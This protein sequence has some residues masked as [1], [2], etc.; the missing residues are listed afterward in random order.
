MSDPN[1]G[2]ANI[3]DDSAT[4]GVQAEA[5]HGDVYVYQVLSDAPPERKF[6]VGVLYLTGGMPARAREC[7]REAV[8]NGQVTSHYCYYLLLAVLSGR[9]LQQVPKED[10]SLLRF[11]QGKLVDKMDDEWTQAIKVIN[12]LLASLQAPDVDPL[13]IEEQLEELIDARRDEILRSLEM[14][15]KGPVQDGFWTR[16]FE[17]ARRDRC[18]H[19]RLQRVWKFFQ[20]EPAKARVRPPRPPDTTIREWIL[21]ITSGTILLASIYHISLQS[22]QHSWSST[23]VALLLVGT[24]CYAFTKNGVEWCFRATRV[25]AKDLMYLTAER[26]LSSTRQGFADKIDRQFDEYFARYVP[27]DVRRAEW[28]THIA[29]IRRVLRDEVVEIYRESRTDAKQVAWLTRYLVANVK[30]RW[31]KGVL[32]E[33]REQLRVSAF[34]KVSFAIGAMVL[35]TGGTVLTWNGL[36]VAPFSV[37]AAGIIMGAVGRSTV[38]GWLRIILEHKRFAADQA[39]STQLLAERNAAFYRWKRK[40]SDRPGD[41]EMAHWLDC[42]RK[43]LMEEA[44]RHYKLQP[45]DLIAH[46]FIEAPAASYKRA[47]VRK[48][49]WRYSRYTILVFLL[50]EDGVRQMT[51]D[52]DFE[53]ATLHNRVRINYRYESVAAVQATEADDAHRTFEL[54][55]MNGAPIKVEVT[56]PAPTVDL[57]TGEDMRTVSQVTLD[58]AGLAS[59]LHILEGVAAEGKEWISQERKREQDG[60]ADLMDTTDGLLG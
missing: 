52:L 17:S 7:I 23:A 5:V 20:P 34:T 18:D 24:G 6:E 21:S 15:L 12:A 35:T 11:A 46:A 43:A 60:L 45:H 14:L 58:S 53:K 40:L 19:Q 37:T 4:V 56:G 47:R 22:W 48:G 2:R 33:Y 31:Q 42:D 25:K 39:E 3:A 55:L 13:A 54:T 16:S 9:T 32:W 57:E 51:V 36:H 29:G 50:T 28:L 8:L 27:R 30:D 26:R 1:L 49:P 10:L 59:T 41:P 38:R 44:M